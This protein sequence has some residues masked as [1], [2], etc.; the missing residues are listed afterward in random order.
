M[1]TWDSEPHPAAPPVDIETSARE[2]AS[3]VE[4]VASCWHTMSVKFFGR[5]STCVYHSACKVGEIADFL[6]PSLQILGDI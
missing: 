2:P 1:V 5:P 4:V 3:V 6:Q